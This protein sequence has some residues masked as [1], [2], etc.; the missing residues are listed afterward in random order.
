MK[1]TD[2]KKLSS[3]I[4]KATK[5]WLHNEAY[6]LLCRLAWTISKQY[7][8]EEQEEAIQEELEKWLKNPECFNW[9][10]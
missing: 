7:D 1:E 2:I 3:F 8:E 10:Y 9:D 6:S 5:E 4:K